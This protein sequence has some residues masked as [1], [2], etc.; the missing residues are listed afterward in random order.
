[1]SEALTN[2]ARYAQASG[3]RVE[4]HRERDDVVV[5]VQDDGVGG[6]DIGAGTGL[7]G[8]ADRIAALDGTLRVHSPRGGGTQ[9]TARIPCAAGARVAEARQ[10]SGQPPADA[11]PRAVLE[12]P[13]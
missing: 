5:E 11:P 2:V 10:K 1:V 7:R 12:A 6:A 4:I 9:I 13:P 3:A 8:L